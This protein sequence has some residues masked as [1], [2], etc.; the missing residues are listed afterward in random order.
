[1]PITLPIATLIAGAGAAGASA[2]GAHAQSSATED[3]AKIQSDYN[4]KALA[5]AEAQRQWQREQYQAYLDRTAPFRQ[6][7]QAASQ[8]LTAAL[9]RG[10]NIP[11]AQQLAL[12]ASSVGALAT[13]GS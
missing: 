9:A 7:G 6:A 3:A 13:K 1:M 4:T 2:F 10:P 11:T 5:D 8:T 12:P